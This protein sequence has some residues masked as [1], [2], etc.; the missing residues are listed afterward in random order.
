MRHV[1]INRSS[2]AAV[3]S[4]MSSRSIVRDRNAMPPT[5]R[6]MEMASRTI[7]TRLDQN[8]RVLDKALGP[9]QLQRM[10]SNTDVLAGPPRIS[11]HGLDVGAP[12]KLVTALGVLAIVVSAS[13][14]HNMKLLRL[15]N[16]NDRCQRLCC[17]KRSC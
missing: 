5:A 12:V 2:S 4:S 7:S 14:T 13:V 17:R 6:P 9:S 10:L 3:F 16:V 15:G 8:T 11:L 1:C